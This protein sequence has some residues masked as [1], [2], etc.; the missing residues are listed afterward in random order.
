MDLNMLCPL[1]L[2]WVS[3]K[4]ESTLV[5]TPNDNWSMEMDAQLCKEVYVATI[6]GW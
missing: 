4:L 1:L 3:T 2:H 6:I 5:V